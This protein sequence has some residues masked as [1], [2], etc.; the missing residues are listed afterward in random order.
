MQV[1]SEY[2]R[3][4]NGY[5]FWRG[6]YTVRNQEYLAGRNQLQK[7]SDDFLQMGYASYLKWM[8]LEWG[9]AI[10]KPE[11]PPRD[12]WDYLPEQLEIVLEYRNKAEQFRVLFPYGKDTSYVPM[13]QVFTLLGQESFPPDGSVYFESPSGEGMF[14]INASHNIDNPRPGIIHGPPCDTVR[15]INENEWFLAVSSG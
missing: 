13:S 15:V 14:A 2:N 9:A 10:G 6:Q 8:R 3:W 12:T 11:P 4:L 7:L 1:M 5:G